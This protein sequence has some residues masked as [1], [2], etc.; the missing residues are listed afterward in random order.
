MMTHTMIDIDAL[1]QF[2]VVPLLDS[3]Q[4]IAAYLADILEAGDDGLVAVA[5][6]D[7]ARAPAC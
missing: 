5:L 1:P 3:E 4:A 2:D 7:I 6:G